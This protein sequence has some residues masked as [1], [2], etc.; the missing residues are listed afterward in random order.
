MTQS[1]GFTTSARTASVLPPI[2]SLVAA[3]ADYPVA[4]V[5]D[6]ANVNE[7]F[8]ALCVLL[9]AT[10]SP[11][12]AAMVSERFHAQFLRPLAKLLGGR[13]SELGAAL[14]ASYV[15]DLATMRTDWNRPR[16]TDLRG[17]KRQ[18]LWRRQ[19]NPAWARTA[20]DQ[21]T[22]QQSGGWRV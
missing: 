1:S 4:Q 9:R 14:L 8:H 22:A 21:D 7:S 17:E 12:V 19:F 3:G 20:N 15:I 10:G 11:A 5:L 2:A 6:D 13:G 18:P 16:W